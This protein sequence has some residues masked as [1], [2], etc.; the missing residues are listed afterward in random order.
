MSRS[1][2]AYGSDYSTRTWRTGVVHRRETRSYRNLPSGNKQLSPTMQGGLLI[3]GI[4][5]FLWGGVC[6]VQGAGDNVCGP[7]KWPVGGLVSSNVARGRTR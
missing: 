5:V 2:H 7:A 3:C 1:H 6:L 4:I